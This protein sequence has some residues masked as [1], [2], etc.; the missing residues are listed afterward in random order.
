MEQIEA[1]KASIRFL[2]SELNKL[3]LKENENHQRPVLT[4]N[5]ED[6]TFWLKVPGCM[7]SVCSISKEEDCV[8]FAND[9][10]GFWVDKNGNTVEGDVFFH[11]RE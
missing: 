9:E 4:H 5:Y 11:K 1:L 6:N 3:I 7:G 2:Q 8:W 10:D